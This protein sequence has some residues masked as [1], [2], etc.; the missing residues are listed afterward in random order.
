MTSRSDIV[1]E[2]RSWIGTPW[3][4]QGRTKGVA[5][6]CLGIA[7]AAAELLGQMPA[8]LAVPSYNRLPLGNQL[9]HVFDESMDRIEE[10]EAKVGDLV[11]FSLRKQ[12]AAGT[13]EPRPI[14]VGIL[15]PWRHD[16]E[17]APFALCH[18]ML[19]MGVVSEQPYDLTRLRLT[20]VG[21]Y[22]FRGLV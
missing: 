19:E 16:G 13:V 17:G 7:Q 21:Y 15:T 18:A 11:L 8:H 1:R 3:V 5:C 14:H 6:D 20:P 12:P 9:R 2:V 22:R 10:E 4:H